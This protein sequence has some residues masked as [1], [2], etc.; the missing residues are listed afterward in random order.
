M[1]AG[2]QAIDLI[3]IADRLSALSAPALA[4][5]A[6]VTGALGWWGFTWAHKA[7]LALKDDLVAEVRKDRDYWR[8]Q[9]QAA[10][11][12]NAKWA[13][14]VEQITGILETITGTLKQ[15]QAKP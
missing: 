2:A 14:H 11:A 13:D 9:A 6:L 15:Q 5:A 1:V 12:T 3:Q 8:D 4:F 7:Q 10:A